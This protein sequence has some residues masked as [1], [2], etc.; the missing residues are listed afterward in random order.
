MVAVLKDWHPT[1]RK[2]HQC[3]F[4]AHIIK[5]GEKYH[6]QTVAY[7]GTVYDNILCEE[8]NEVLGL[9]YEY[10]E[11]EDL[12][13]SEEFMERVWDVLESYMPKEEVHKM[14]NHEQV[15]E[16]LKHKDEILKEKQEFKK[17]YGYW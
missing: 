10:W 4:C 8:C 1:A 16:V 12:T 14:T 13:G 5:P 11:Y 3:P 15:V 7:D 6:R 2:E 9:L 17:K